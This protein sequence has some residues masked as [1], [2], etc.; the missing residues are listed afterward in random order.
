M[1]HFYKQ[2]KNIAKKD[3]DGLKGHT[4]NEAYLKVTLYFQGPS[5]ARAYYNS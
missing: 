3:T 4:L 5:W 2:F 1:W